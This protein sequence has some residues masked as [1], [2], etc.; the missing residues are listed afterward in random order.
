MRNN[1]NR[2][3]LSLGLGTLMVLFWVLSVSAFQNP[4]FREYRSVRLGMAMTEVRAK[5]GEPVMKS[6]EQDYYVF[7]P[8]ETAQIAYDAT[9]KV[10]A[11][12]TDYTGGVGAPDFMTIV[13]AGL[14]ERPDGSM[15]K[16][17]Q[18]KAEGF[19]V[20][21]NRSAATV[22]TITVTLQTIPK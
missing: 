2:M 13:G 21:Y 11:I 18:H 5:L 10:V 15:F 16:M 3:V 1:T 22:P 6:D 20:S 19:W 17:V 4:I 9:H 12:S 8:N 14:L 7:S